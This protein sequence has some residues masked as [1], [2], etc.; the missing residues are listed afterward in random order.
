M[1]EV[2]GRIEAVGRGRKKPK[3]KEGEV[4]MMNSDWQAIGHP[5][6]RVLLKNLHTNDQIVVT[7]RDLFSLVAIAEEVRRTY[8][9]G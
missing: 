1:A 3:P 7:I 2:S 8:D 4:L 5:G 6:G 9:I